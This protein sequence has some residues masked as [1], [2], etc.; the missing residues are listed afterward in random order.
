ME[1]RHHL[2]GRFRATGT[3]RPVRGDNAMTDAQLEV[4]IRRAIGGD[5]DACDFLL[6]IAAA[7]EHPLALVM[8]ALLADVPADLARASALAVTRRDRQIVEI[9][10]AH[11]DGDLEQ[12]DALAREH[13][14]DHPDSVLVAWIAAGAASP[15]GRGQPPS[16]D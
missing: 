4:A 13:L 14:V 10:R 15:R 16:V 11:L 9:A 7:A 3:Q 2:V 5:T 1:A 6:A 8:A 12:V